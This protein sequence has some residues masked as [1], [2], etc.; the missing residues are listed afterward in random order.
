MTAASTYHII[1]LTECTRNASI[2][3]EIQIAIWNKLREHPES[4][5]QNM[6]LVV[7]PVQARQIAGS[8]EHENIIQHL[9]EHGLPF[10]TLPYGL[11]SR[12]YGLNAA[13]EG[14]EWKAMYE[15]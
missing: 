14:I 6:L 11:V 7:T 5:L 3:N 13:I 12:L 4:N 9:R 10:N 8:Q 2:R 15:P 1:R